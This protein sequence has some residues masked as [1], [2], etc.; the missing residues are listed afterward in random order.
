[1][2]YKSTY[3]G[4]I[5]IDLKE[6]QII[7]LLEI[8]IKDYTVTH[9]ENQVDYRINKVKDNSIWIDRLDKFIRKQRA[10]KL[11]QLGI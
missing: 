7:P 6:G 9:G 8:I 3:I 10:K 11:H 5:S 2:Y 1:M 4:T